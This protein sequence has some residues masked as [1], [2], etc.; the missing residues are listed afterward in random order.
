MICGP[1]PDPWRR[2]IAI[3]FPELS[4]STTAPKRLPADLGVNVTFT[5]QL[6]PAE[7]VVFA[8][9]VS[10]PASEKSRPAAPNVSMAVD[11]SVPLATKVMATGIEELVVPTFTEP[12]FTAV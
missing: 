12:K 9:Q 11:S 1:N 2:P 10:E 6:C 8:V 5:V 4:L 7:Y 3:V